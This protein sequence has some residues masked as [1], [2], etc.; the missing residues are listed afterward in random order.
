MLL[1]LLWGAP[2]CRDRDGGRGLVRHG[3]GNTSVWE[4]LWEVRTWNAVILNEDFY[5]RYFLQFKV[6]A[7]D[8]G[9]EKIKSHIKCVIIKKLKVDAT[10]PLLFPSEATMC[11]SFLK[12]LVEQNRSENPSHQDNR[13]VFQEGLACAN[14]YAIF[15][16]ITLPWPS[17]GTMI[18]NWKPT[19]TSAQVCGTL[20]K[21]SVTIRQA[22]T[23]LTGF[24]WR[25]L[26]SRSAICQT[27]LALP[28]CPWYSTGLQTV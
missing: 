3:W 27:T 24:W 2:K 26:T 18:S 22:S 12:E 9:L 19:L 1:C 4:V 14:L 8:D 10:N 6:T 21:P 23:Y 28:L 25:S 5:F 11:K 17:S 20:P 13:Y 7:A 16:A 15:Q